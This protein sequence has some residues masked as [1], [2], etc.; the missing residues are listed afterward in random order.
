[1]EIVQPPKRFKHLE[2][3]SELLH[4]KEKES[5]QPVSQ[6]KEELDIERYLK[7][8]PSEADLQLDPLEYWISVQHCYPFLF[9]VACDVLSIPASSASVERVF[10]TSGEVTRGKRNRLTDR[11]LERETMLRKNKM[12]I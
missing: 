6:S 2:L 4:G 11:M 12:Y 1:M 8:T 5:E 10:S 3:V 9:P 7:S